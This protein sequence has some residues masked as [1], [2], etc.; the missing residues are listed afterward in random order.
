MA[1]GVKNLT[2]LLSGSLVKAK[3]DLEGISGFQDLVVGP[4]LHLCFAW[5]TTL[6]LNSYTYFL[7]LMWFLQG[8]S[9]RADRRTVLCRR[10]VTTPVHRVF[11]PQTLAPSILHSLFSA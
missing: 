9:F 10:S 8:V 4:A 5:V 2:P 11:S 1:S 7:A 3:P 6:L